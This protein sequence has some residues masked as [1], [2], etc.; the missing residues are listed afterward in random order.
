MLRCAAL[1][2]AASAWGGGGAA[3]EGRVGGPHAGGPRGP[4]APSEGEARRGAEAAADGAAAAPDPLADSNL[5]EMAR[6][7]ARRL[8]EIKTMPWESRVA[9]M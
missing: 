8:E 7:H 4:A 6:L 2:A 5:E 3:A 9:E 1:L